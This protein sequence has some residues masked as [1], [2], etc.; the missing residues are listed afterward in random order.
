MSI[1][2]NRWARG[3]CM[4]LAKN[5]CTAMGNI[6]FTLRFLSFICAATLIAETKAK[7]I[8]LYLSEPDMVKLAEELW[9]QNV[10]KKFW[11][12]NTAWVTS[13]LI[14]S[15]HHRHIFGNVVGLALPRATIPGLRDFLLK[16]K[17]GNTKWSDR[18]SLVKMG[19]SNEKILSLQDCRYF[20]LDHSIEQRSNQTYLNHFIKAYHF[21]GRYLTQPGCKINT[22]HPNN[23]KP[24][25]Q[26]CLCTC[27]NYSIK[28]NF[29]LIPE[30]NTSMQVTDNDPLMKLPEKITRPLIKNFTEHQTDK[31]HIPQRRD[32]KDIILQLW[33][34]TF[35]CSWVIDDASTPC[36]GEED[37]QDVYSPFTD[38]SQLRVTYSTY[39]AIYVVVHALHDLQACKPMHGPFSNAS[40]GTI[41]SL[42][43]WQV[44]YYLRKVNFQSILGEAM[45]FD[46]N[47]DPP[48]V[49]QLINWQRNEENDVN[50][51]VH[52]KKVGGY[53]SGASPGH[54]LQVDADHLVWAGGKRKAGFNNTAQLYD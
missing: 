37:L 33:E 54:V 30:H 42:Q 25:A 1:P 48:A 45:S 3:V 4:A 38:V 27:A 46:Q 22:T 40:C 49:F 2:S 41:K 15:T 23:I 16:I 53:N 13:P 7:V 20:C 32:Q 28:S 11:I 17:P 5:C 47:G 26:Q 12:A 44:L 34:V 24:I 36:T 10:T 18:R 21:H 14:S 31:F 52:F 19:N 35:N 29:Y 50:G 39:L 6:F 43:P 8:L 51:V 9:K